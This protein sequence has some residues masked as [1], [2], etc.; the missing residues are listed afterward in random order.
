MKKI[1]L[2]LFLFT[3]PVFVFISCKKEEEPEVLEYRQPTVASRTEVVTIPQGLQ[4]S[5]DPGA[6]MGV[7]Y[8]GL[9]NGLA[10]MATSF[11]VPADV[12]PEN[13]KSSAS[14]YHWTYGGYSYWMTFSATST[15][16]NWKYEYEFP[17]MSRFTFIEANELKT[18]LQGNWMIYDPEATH[19]ILWKY[20]WTLNSVQDFAANIFLYGY[21]GADSINFDILGRVNNSGYLKLYEGSLKIAEIIWNSDGSGSWWIY[22]ED[23]NHY[24][25][26]W[27]I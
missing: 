11:N 7:A 27:S 24:S 1:S 12:E 19:S 23:G 8:M 26:S 20:D 16:Y 3:L 6:Q 14:V 4:N 25:G 5:E 10:A 17:G 22:S 21:N 13:T 15:H 9:A 18:G 2:I